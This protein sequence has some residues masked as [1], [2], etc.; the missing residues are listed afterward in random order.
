MRIY[1]FLT[2]V[3]LFANTNTIGQINY[4]NYHALIAKAETHIS[5]ENFDDAL[6]LYDSAFAQVEYVYPKDYVVAAQLA[7]ILKDSVKCM[8]YIEKAMRCGLKSYCL[9]LLYQLNSFLTYEDWQALESLE[10][11][12]RREYLASIDLNLNYEFTRRYREEQENKTGD[13]G[14]EIIRSNYFR[15]ISLMDSMPFVSD[16]IIGI[17]ETILDKNTDN[18]GAELYDCNLDNSKVMV[19]LLHSKDPI[20]HIGFDRLMTAIEL[21]YLH[22]REMFYLY[23]YTPNRGEWEWGSIKLCPRP[24]LTLRYSHSDDQQAREKADYNRNRIGLCTYDVELKNIEIGI[25]YK[26]KLRFGYR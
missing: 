14:Y 4:F 5:K 8:Y 16:R 26:M 11:N 23:D 19:T 7:A 6:I 10:I 22:P 3:F 9:K 20:S 2:I 25:K 18:K 1:L 12:F 15:I 21:G 24:V 13:F 17:D